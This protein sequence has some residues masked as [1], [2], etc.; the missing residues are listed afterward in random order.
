[1]VKDGEEF[2]NC[3]A[4]A[5]GRQAW[6]KGCVRMYQQGRTPNKRRACSLTIWM[7]RNWL[8]AIHDAAKEEGLATS[9]WAREKL[10]DALV[11]ANRLSWREN[12]PAAVLEQ[13]REREKE[14]DRARMRK[15]LAARRGA[16][17]ASDGVERGDGDGAIKTVEDARR[18]VARLEAEGFGL[19]ASKKKEGDA[20]VAR[21]Q[22]R[23]LAHQRT[24]LAT[25]K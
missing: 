11:Q 20:P 10:G 23:R 24:R 4:R 2:H 8:A 22:V 3:R 25:P 18:V 17:A 5:S 12:A 19:G 14:Q 9:A 7:K 21:S 16:P 13:F 1:M 15:R 6:C